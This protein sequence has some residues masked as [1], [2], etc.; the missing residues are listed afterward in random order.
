MPDRRATRIAPCTV[1]ASRSGLIGRTD[2]LGL[3]RDLQ[4]TVGAG[5]T[6]VVVVEGPAGIGKSALVE[7]TMH[8]AADAGLDVHV[9]R[10]RTL[11]RGLPFAPLAEALDLRAG[12]DDA[13]RAAL[14]RLLHGDDVGAVDPSQRRWRLIDGMVELL[15]HRTATTPALLV[16]EDLHWADQDT[17]TALAR[18]TRTVHTGLLL[19]ASC[20]SAPRDRT[21][22]SALEQLEASGAQ[23]LTLQ[24]LTRKEVTRLAADRLGTDPAPSLEQLLD[25]AGGNPFFVTS[26]IEALRADGAIDTTSGAAEANDA[27]LPPSLHVALVRW[28]GFL[29]PSTV[30]VLT[31]AAVLGESIPI[32]W[33]SAVTGRSPAALAGLLEPAHRAGILRPEHDRLSFVHGLVRDALYEDLPTLARGAM[34]AQAADALAG[35]DVGPAEL[36]HHLALSLTSDDVPVAR[37]LLEAA[38]ALVE[39][40]ADLAAEHVAA[41][42]QVLPHDDPDRTRARVVRARAASRTGRPD[43]A[44]QLV[45]ELDDPG[46]DD[47]TRLELW[48]TITLARHFRGAHTGTALAAYEQLVRDAELTSHVRARHLALIA[49]ACRW[50]DPSR[51]ENLAAQVLAE[52]ADA[53]SRMLALSAQG[54]AALLRFDTEG[55]GRTTAQA[56]RTARAAGPPP[57]WAGVEAARMYAYVRTVDPRTVEDALAVLSTAIEGASTAGHLYALPRLHVELAF[58][59]YLCGRFETAIANLHTGLELM[60]QTGHV[61]DEADAHGMLADIHLLMGRDDVVAEHEAALDRLEY[62]EARET[63]AVVT[64]A[65]ARAGQALLREDPA[66]A[67]RLAQPAADTLLSTAAHLQAVAG[68][69]SLPYLEAA[70]RTGRHDRA[71]AWLAHL[72]RWAAETDGQVL[73]ADIAARARALVERTEQAAEDA[74]VVLGRSSVLGRMLGLL[75]M[76]EVLADCGATGRA[77][78]VLQ[79]GRGLADDAGALRLTAR[80]DRALRHLGVGRPARARTARPDHGWAALTDAERRVV[81]LVADGLTYRAV[82][83]ALVVSR[84]TVESHV[85]RA[86]RKLDIHSRQE[87]AEQ[88]RTHVEGS[89]PGSP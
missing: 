70:V 18:I 51:A 47:D 85:A 29:P 73:T 88:Y 38:E 67:W 41:V 14:A 76:G 35:L 62:L 87:L 22:E 9:G 5:G 65:F 31:M 75:G 19:L 33:L 86:F 13:R 8:E 30:E 49:F 25:G 32:R 27:T 4:V 59:S 52:P 63:T 74:V 57:T 10:A 26:M 55:A 11:D 42:L 83:E 53:D 1:G 46:L 71:R 80:Y 89:D 23:R 61:Q 82:G 77:V 69:A 58:G 72:Q 60:Q 16:I 28:L 15:E 48:H 7:A 43:E 40:A 84:R 17:L 34:H 21:V 20:R 64:T 6:A 68:M 24:P 39:P 37:R 54:M 78:E 12:H 2:V 36:A 79:E 66:T 56:L 44:E 45:H 81:A 50:H 3:L